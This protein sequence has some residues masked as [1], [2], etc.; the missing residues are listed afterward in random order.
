[1]IWLNLCQNTVFLILSNVKIL[2]PLERSKMKRDELLS[3]NGD[4]TRIFKSL[5]KLWNSVSFLG[6]SFTFI[7][8]WWRVFGKTLLSFQIFSALSPNFQRTVFLFSVRYNFT[9]LV[10]WRNFQRRFFEKALGNREKNSGFLS[11]C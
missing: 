2:S 8:F 7:Y 4:S 10:D 1:M 5:R 11:K 9:R 6:S 3:K